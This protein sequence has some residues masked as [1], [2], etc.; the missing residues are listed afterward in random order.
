MRFSDGATE[1]AAL[2]IMYEDV[3]PKRRLVA[4]EGGGTEADHRPSRP[5]MSSRKGGRKQSIKHWGS[6]YR[7]E[8]HITGLHTR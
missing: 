2:E 7:K 1:E 4:F 8:R 5:R 3:E 6:T